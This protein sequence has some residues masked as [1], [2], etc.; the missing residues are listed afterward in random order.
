MSMSMQDELK[1]AV[2]KRKTGKMQADQQ[3]E[4]TPDVT[5]A[6]EQTEETAA[7]GEEPKPKPS[8][9]EQLFGLFKLIVI[10][11]GL[12]FTSTRGSR[13]VLATFS[14]HT[15][16][17]ALVLPVPFVKSMPIEGLLLFTAL[18][19]AISEVGMPPY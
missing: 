3:D 9:P 10:L 11:Y 8:K 5:T 4:V 18:G 7:K 16:V 2:G 14:N 12:Y 1:M 13:W 15:I 6:G 19:V 17:S